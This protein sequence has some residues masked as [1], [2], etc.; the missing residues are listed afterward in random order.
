MGRKRKNLEEYNFLVLKLGKIPTVKQVFSFVKI[1]KTHNLNFDATY[2]LFVS[3][4][5]TSSYKERIKLK[6]GELVLDEY[7]NTLKGRKGPDKIVSTF[8]IDYWVDKKGMSIEEAKIEVSKLQ[9]ANA[10]KHVYKRHQHPIHEEYYIHKGYTQEEAEKERKK[11]IA[12]TYY[13]CNLDKLSPEEYESFLKR[14]ALRETTLLERYGTV[15][16]NCKV[17]KESLKFLIPIYKELRR[18]GIERTDINWGI[19][20]SKE[21]TTGFEGRNFSYDFT[22]RSK[23][24]IIEYNGTFWHSRDDMTWK[25]P[26]VTFDCAKET[27]EIKKRAANNLGFDIIT[28]WSD[29]DLNERKKEILGLLC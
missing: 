10:K 28:V 24:I 27:E 21:F 14:Y 2:E 16:M 23:K 5:S 15:C 29:E 7:L 19:T 26:W 20:G 8:T 12:D 6:D 17:S 4:W 9:S 25:N 22:I 1:K 18:S 11:F 3:Y 13:M